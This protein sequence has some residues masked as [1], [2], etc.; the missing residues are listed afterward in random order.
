[1][2]SA[3]ALH[4]GEWWQWKLVLGGM[5]VQDG[6]QVW[7]LARLGAEDVALDMDSIF[8][9]EDDNWSDSSSEGSVDG[10]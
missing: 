2:C 3:E 7:E 1:M 5:G 6:W 9:D 10:V 8:V 4:K